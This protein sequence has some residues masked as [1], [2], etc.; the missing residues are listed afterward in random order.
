MSYDLLRFSL[1]FRRFVTVK[2]HIILCALFSR[3]ASS[4]RVLLSF[5]TPPKQTKPLNPFL[6]VRFS[7]KKTL[8]KKRVSFGN[9]PQKAAHHS[10]RVYSKRPQPR[11]SRARSQPS[12]EP[13]FLCARVFDRPP[14]VTRR[15]YIC[16]FDTRYPHFLIHWSL[17]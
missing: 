10:L 5:T 15:K 4:A 16:G 1:L 14:L 3:R 8:L 17:E 6:R 9:P 12:S 2:E 11:P 7:P 13:N